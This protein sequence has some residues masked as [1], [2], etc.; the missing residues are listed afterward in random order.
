MKRY[1]LLTVIIATCLNCRVQAQTASD[2]NA[3]FHPLSISAGIGG[4]RIF[5]NGNWNN[6]GH[7]NHI[8]PSLSVDYMIRPQIGI[9]HI[10]LG[11]TGS[12]TTVEANTFYIT[13]PS[14]WPTDPD[15]LAFHG[16]YTAYMLGVRGT[17]HFLTHVNGL[18][19]YAGIMGEYVTP[20]WGPMTFNDQP[21]HPHYYLGYLAGI[22]YFFL[23]NVGVFGEAGKNGFSIITLGLSLSL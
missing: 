8:S 7:V 6:I 19:P 14:N 1:T 4:G 18:D 2:G 10:S 13:V 9:G 11:L 3:S 21:Q 17:Y 22:R 15:G 20:T 5:Y 16:K 23:P 12:F